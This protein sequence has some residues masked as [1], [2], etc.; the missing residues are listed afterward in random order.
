ME[1]SKRELMDYLEREARLYRLTANDSLRRN[2][3][4]TGYPMTE[5]EIIP[6]G[7]IDALLVDFINCIGTGQGLDEGFSVKYLKET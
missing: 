1:P 6:Q 3:H 7:V 5:R 2:E 4:L